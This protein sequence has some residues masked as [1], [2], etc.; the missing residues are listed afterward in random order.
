MYVCTMSKTLWKMINTFVQL[1][2]ELHVRSSRNVYVIKCPIADTL[3]RTSE[4]KV[5]YIMHI[6]S[7]INI[8][9][10]KYDAS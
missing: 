8:L 1:A 2:C 6:G 10:V 7:V 9:V 3:Y 5:F 4:R